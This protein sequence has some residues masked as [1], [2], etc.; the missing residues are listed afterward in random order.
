M[1]TITFAMVLAAPAFA[2]WL[3]SPTPGIPRTADGKPNLT[4]PVPRMP[5]GKPD[6]SGLWKPELTP[7]RFDVIQNV[8]DEAIFRPAAEAL[9]LQRAVNLRHDNPVTHCLPA[10]PQAIFA[11]GSTRFYRIVQSPNV[12]ALLY[13]LG[14]FR[15]IYTDGRALPEDPNPTWMGYSI[16]HWE[17]DTLVVQT[18]GFND[19]T[20]LDMVGHP[21]SE[22]L[23]VTE[24]FRRADF[25]H[26]QV[27]VTYD[28]PETMIKPLTISVGV[29]YAADT[30][31]LEYVCN[32]D[33]RDTEHLVGTAKAVA[34]PSPATL[35]KYAGEYVYRNGVTTSRDFFGADQIVSVVQGQLYMK[36]FPLIP[37]TETRF[38]STAGTIE[39]FVDSSGRVTHLILSAAEGDARYERAH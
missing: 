34:H 39:F 36:D 7:Y 19:R 27:Q 13:E 6:L 2:Q 33:E 21:H 12:V 3:N 24:K 14:G 9:F 5:D 18:A 1:R 4:A 23:R 10:G 28:D 26:M 11:A 31:M 8:K 38:D 17:G 16:G 20:W 37:Q 35:A 29:N 30:D 15:Q 25:G 22:R 32:E